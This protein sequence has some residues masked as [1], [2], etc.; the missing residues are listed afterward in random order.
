M[1]T[2]VDPAGA[3]WQVERLWTLW[4][5]RRHGRHPQDLEELAFWFVGWPLWPLEWLIAYVCAAVARFLDH[6]WR[7]V[8]TCETPP[9]EQL[10]WLVRGGHASLAHVVEV[11]ERIHAGDA[12]LWASADRQRLLGPGHPHLTVDVAA[13]HPRSDASTSPRSSA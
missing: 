5:V 4:R 10:T 9:C 12:T 3:E 1:T 6:P 7:V 11:A 8:A 2:V 13:P